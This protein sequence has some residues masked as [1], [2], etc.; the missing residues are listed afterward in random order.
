MLMMLMLLLGKPGN[1]QRDSPYHDRLAERDS[2][3]RRK[4]SI[5]N[6]HL[7][8]WCFF[9]GHLVPLTLS[10]LRAVVHRPAAMCKEH[11]YLLYIDKMVSRRQT[12][13]TESF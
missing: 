3:V 11:Q 12:R 10:R 8:V 9:F 4:I 13:Q 2:K 6:F 1:T 7:E 5:L